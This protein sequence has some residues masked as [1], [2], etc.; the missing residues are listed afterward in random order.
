VYEADPAGRPQET[1]AALWLLKP[2]QAAP[3]GPALLKSEQPALDHLNNDHADVIETLATHSGL[4]PGAWRAIGLDPEGMDIAVETGL[5]SRLGRLDFPVQV[6]GFQALR[7]CM[8]R[9]L[10]A[11][12]PASPGATT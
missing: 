5:G 3:A 4:A 2:T 6:W 1:D 10:A 7:A 11:A 12:T 8:K 9:L